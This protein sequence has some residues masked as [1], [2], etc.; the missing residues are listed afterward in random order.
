MIKP[1]SSGLKKV[2]SIT[3]IDHIQAKNCS[4]FNHFC[5]CSGRT[6]IWQSGSLGF[7]YQSNTMQ[8]QYSVS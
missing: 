2:S 4:V 3:H 7:L 6:G 8:G 5:W 1:N